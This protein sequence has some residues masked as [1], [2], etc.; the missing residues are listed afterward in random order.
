MYYFDKSNALLISP[1]EPQKSTPV[2]YS[3]LHP[4][5]YPH[6]FHLTIFI[7]L[8][9]FFLPQTLN[10]ISLG[11]SVMRHTVEKLSMTATTLLHTL[12]QSKVYTQSYGHPKSQKSHL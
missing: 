10:P 2:G 1:W 8:G 6:I 3:F 5:Y 4:F 7:Y 9:I 11:T 12:S